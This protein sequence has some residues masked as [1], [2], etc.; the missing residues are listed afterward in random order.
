MAKDK[1][2]GSDAM[3]NGRIPEKMVAYLRPKQSLML[4]AGNP[5]NHWS[6]PLDNR[7]TP[8]FARFDACQAFVV[9]V[10]SEAFQKSGLV[11][12]CGG[13]YHFQIQKPEDVVKVEFENKPFRSLRWVGI[14]SRSEGG[15]AYKVVTPEG[16]LVDLRE[17]VVMECLFEGVIHPL[18]SQSQGV[19]TYFTGEFVWAV[20][21][22]QSRLVLVGSKLYW[23][24]RESATRRTM[25]VISDGD[26][27]VGGMYRSRKGEEFILLG[28]GMG[29]G[30]KYLYKVMRGGL[31][32]RSWQELVDE[33]VN[34]L[35][36][37]S[38]LPFWHYSGSFTMVEKVGKVDVPLGMPKAF[39]KKVADV[40][41]SAAA[42]NRA[43]CL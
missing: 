26:L 38:V 10:D 28:R 7:E 11:W 40:Q 33:D 30:R 23:E 39:D 36:K 43:S 3:K 24:L 15:V 18:S 32:G 13:Q 12:A 17:D 20:M 21:G 22:S 6:F 25:Q 27:E 34:V 2:N 42:W 1:A 9:P 41:V 4:G 29:K 37:P 31:R 14:D 35:C 16:W 8:G 5:H 19:G